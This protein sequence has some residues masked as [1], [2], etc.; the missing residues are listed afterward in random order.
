[1]LD[2]DELI[3][4]VHEEEPPAAKLAEAGKHEEANQCRMLRGAGSLYNIRISV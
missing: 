1:L 4:L 2:G 3:E